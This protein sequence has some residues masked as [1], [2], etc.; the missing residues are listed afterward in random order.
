RT[1]CAMPV[2][3]SSLTRHSAHGQ[4]HRNGVG[5]LQEFLALTGGGKL[6]TASPSTTLAFAAAFR[7][8]IISMM[9]SMPHSISSLFIDLTPPQCS[10]FI[11]RGTSKAQI[12]M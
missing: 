2:G 6:G 11:S 9:V 8:A 4:V 10:N 12:F 5:P 1:C 7:L 3:S